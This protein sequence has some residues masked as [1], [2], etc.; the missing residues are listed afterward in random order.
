MPKSY[1]SSR[2]KKALFFDLNRTLIDDKASRR[3]CFISVLNDFTARW[4]KERTEWDPHKIALQYE[5]N[6]QSLK[7]KKGKKRVKLSTLSQQKKALRAA[8]K[9]YPLIVNDAFLRVFFKHM[10][11]QQP[12]HYKLYPNTLSTLSKLAASYKLG[13]ISNRSNIDLA[14]I[15]LSKHFTPEQLITP[16]NSK[17]RKPSP[18]IF[19]YALS[20]FGVHPSEAVM[21]GDSWRNDI[22]GAA[23]AGMDAIWLQ[24]E[25][26]RGSGGSRNDRSG[27]S[28][29]T[30]RVRADGSGV[31]S[32]VIA[33]RKLGKKKL[34]IIS[35]IAQLL[36][37]L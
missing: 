35:D 13:L 17:S 11:Q 30:S 32:G 16:L 8:L 5:R 36:D 15:G 25:N 29:R 23:S 20:T 12:H 10:R 6:L 18:R 34:P 9:P 27:G 3:A 19:R 26:R 28:A 37:I 7:A 4:D 22:V 2:P 1:F 21:I 14:R 33:H 24:R 31:Q